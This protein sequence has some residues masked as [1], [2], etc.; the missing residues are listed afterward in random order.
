MTLLL[1][2]FNVC[3]LTVSPSAADDSSLLLSSSLL[4]LLVALLVCSSLLVSDSDSE[5]SLSDALTFAVPFLLA[6][7]S[8]ASPAFGFCQLLKMVSRFTSAL[9]LSLAAD[10]PAVCVFRFSSF[11][12]ILDVS[13]SPCSA[14]K[15]PTRPSSRGDGPE[16]TFLDSFPLAFIFDGR[17]GGVMSRDERRPTAG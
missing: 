5:V 11:L 6:L 12:N 8:L 15:D 4:T 2:A 13:S 7:S 17:G 3:F 10:Q 9:P 16:E 14:R 1:G